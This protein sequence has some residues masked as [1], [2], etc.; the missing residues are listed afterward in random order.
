VSSLERLGTLPEE[1]RIELEVDP[2][3]LRIAIPKTQRVVR[4]YKCAIVV[5]SALMI[6]FMCFPAIGLINALE[7]LFYKLPLNATASVSSVSQERKTVNKLVLQ[8]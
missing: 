5:R 1:P 7:V 2:L 4:Y 8:R 3:G 6:V